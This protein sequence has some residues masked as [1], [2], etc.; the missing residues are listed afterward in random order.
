MKKLYLISFLIC[1]CLN[2]YSQE[3]YNVLHVNGTIMIDSTNTPIKTGDKLKG[4]IKFRFS[5]NNDKAVLL[6]S[7]KGRFVLF[8]K[9]KNK[10]N[11]SELKFYLQKN[12]LPIK[13]FTAT[14]SNDY[15]TTN[16]F[17]K[18]KQLFTPKKIKIFKIPSNIDSYYFIEYLLDQKKIKK[19]LNISEGGFLMLDADIFQI[20]NQ[21]SKVKN[22]SINF[23]DAKT[24]KN[25][26]IK[27]MKIKCY[28]YE[29]I[30]NELLNYRKVLH[31]QN[32][33]SAKIKEHL[34][35]FL[36]DT[37]GTDIKLADFEIK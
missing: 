10:Q 9:E 35:L 6:S 14:R 36:K 11:I 22:V 19:R 4:N 7:T 28:D 26:A 16:L 15:A 1:Y 30:L 37:Y 23:H 21:N 24:G 5:S 27:S 2:S 3:F 34:S 13:D 8:A 18:N 17:I 25:I 29:N 20:K 31:S 32:Y 33:D 12:I